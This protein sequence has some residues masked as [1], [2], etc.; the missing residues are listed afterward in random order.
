M[1]EV[2]NSY[3]TI[4]LATVALLAV[5]FPILW[6]WTKRPK[7]EVS[8]PEINPHS[9]EVAIKNVGK[10]I[11]VNC[12]VRITL[13]KKIEDVLSMAKQAFITK[14]N[15]SVKI[16]EDYVAWSI[17][18][19]P[20][21]INIP[22]LLSDRALIGVVSVITNYDEG[23]KVASESAFNPPRAILEAKENKT[24][25]GSIIFGADNC[26]PMNAKFY[27]SFYKTGNSLNGKI[28]LC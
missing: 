12:Y 20:V 5:F 22:P 18:P 6:N 23:L 13:E 16:F 7:L 2:I 21:R 28:E 8:L 3:S 9:I 14:G 11:A 4:I 15:P 17:S 24:Y 25:S 26:K 27:I 1:I 19:N 10:S